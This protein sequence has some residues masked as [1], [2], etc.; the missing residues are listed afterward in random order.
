MCGRY[1]S[2]RGHEELVVEFEVEEDH[3]DGT[4]TQAKYNVAP[5]DTVP[6][7]IERMAVPHRDPDEQVPMSENPADDEDDDARSVDDLV[8]AALGDGR[9]EQI[10]ADDDG[11]RPVRQLRELRWG[12]V[13]SWSKDASG[14]A[15]MINARV[16]TFLE[17]SAFKRA[18]LSRRCLVPADGWY[19]WQVS[20]TEKDAK[21][22]PRKQ[23][24][25]MNLADGEPLAFGGVYEFWRDAELHADDPQAWLVTFSIITT[26][27]EPGLDTIHDRMPLVLPKDRWADW[28]DPAVKDAPS[29]R[30]LTL[31][32]PGGRFDALPVTSRVNSVRNDGPELL[33][34]APADSLIGVVDPA[35]GELLGGPVADPL[36]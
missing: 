24:F 33:E 20:P 1:A 29:V 10:V 19:E 23:P 30:A 13:P 11:A 35:T 15:R 3:L 9:P 22:K 5:T 12:L 25:F 34:P 8:T 2:S 6:V 7:V 16:E 27:A 31:D 14:G 32:L 21:G 36:F 18:A 28:L 4:R 17:K 26:A